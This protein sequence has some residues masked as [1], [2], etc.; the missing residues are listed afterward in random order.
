MKRRKRKKPFNDDWAETNP[1]KLR[2]NSTIP[3][4]T[5]AVCISTDNLFDN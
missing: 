1:R 2:S 4:F 5:K 3:H